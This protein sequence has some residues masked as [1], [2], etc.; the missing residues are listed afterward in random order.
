VKIALDAMGGDRAPAET[1]RGAVLAAQELDL[2]I[3]LV[4]PGGVIEA[5]LKKHATD[6]RI[7]IV[8]A[9]D[10]IAME[11]DRIVQA[12]RQRRDA[13]INVATQMVRSGEAQAV[14]SAGNTGAVMA[15]ALFTLGRIPG[16]ERP[17]IGTL[18][19]YNAGR[20]FLIDAGA[21]LDCRASQLV[22]FAEMG[23]VFMEKVVG[24]A[25]PRVGLLNVGEEA[26]KGNELIQEAYER[27]RE[28]NLN[29]VGNVEGV[30]VHKGIAE[31]VVTDGFTGNIALKVG[32]GIAD[33][34]LETVTGV[35][36]SSP[37]FI[38]AAILLKPALKR[39][40]K[41]LQ[42]EEYGGANLLGVNGIVVIAHG[43]SD[44]LAVKNALRVAK[45]AAESGLLESIRTAF[46]AKSEPSPAAGL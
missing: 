34:I 41:R 38:G 21:N 22:Q 26:S 20:V 6:R 10:T 3:A 1:V 13:S 35:I 5:E 46:A 27:L 12:V 7:S 9:G 11:E 36:K 17:A 44:A 42:Y 24:I 37:L 29:F 2:E 4:G 30:N 43:R 16:N 25:S 19:P 23:S 15:S 40:L 31:V 18:L 39:A 14:V 45:R 8:A 33:Y 32:E 28:S